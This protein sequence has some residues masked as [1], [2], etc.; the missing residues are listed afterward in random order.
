LG[1]PARVVALAASARL[2]LHISAA[3]F[4][5]YE[6][7]LAR[8]RFGD[9]GGLAKEALDGIRRIAVWVKVSGTVTPCS[10]PDDDVFLQCAMAAKADYL[11]TGNLRHFPRTFESTRI[12]TPREFLDLF[13]T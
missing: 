13:N 1:T 8:F 6:E 3:V 7:V 2:V 5:E 9:E 10:D 4:A 12:V 11:V